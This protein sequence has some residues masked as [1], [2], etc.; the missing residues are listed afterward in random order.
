MGGCKIQYLHEAVKLGWVQYRREGGH[1]NTR[2]VQFV[3]RQPCP[4]AYKDEVLVVVFLRIKSL[5][6]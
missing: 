6:Q 2:L 3:L 5:I 1:I 4:D